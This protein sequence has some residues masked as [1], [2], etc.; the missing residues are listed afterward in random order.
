MNRI[1]VGT[2]RVTIDTP[3]V[4][5]VFDSG[6][7]GMYI[8]SNFAAQI[9]KAV[10][11][12]ATYASDNITLNGYQVYNLLINCFIKKSLFSNLFLL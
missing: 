11:A 2:N 6:T 8:H 3:N 1:V 9:A 12:N 4:R 5:G 10:G 7:Q